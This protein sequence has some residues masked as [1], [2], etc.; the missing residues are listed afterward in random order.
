MNTA[1]EGHQNG[2][3]PWI[4]PKVVQLNISETA[5]QLPGLGVDGTPG[6]PDNFRS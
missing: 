3:L 2:K 1:H 4:E 5:A 6:L